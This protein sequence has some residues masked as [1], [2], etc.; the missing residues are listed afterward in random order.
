MSRIR[1]RGL[2]R[3]TKGHTKSTP[4]IPCCMVKLS[5]KLQLRAQGIRHLKKKAIRLNRGKNL[6]KDGKRQETVKVTFLIR[7]NLFQKAKKKI[8]LNP[9]GTLSH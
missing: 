5:I 6:E 1:M 2:R 3:I 9:M 8:L 4:Y 7:Q